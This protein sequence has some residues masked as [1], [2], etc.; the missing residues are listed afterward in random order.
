MKQREKINDIIQDTDRNYAP[1]YGVLP[2][3]IKKHDYK[4]GIEIGVFAGGHAEAILK[5]GAFLVGIDPYMDYEPGMPRLDNQSDW[6]ML[7]N[8]VMKRLYKYRYEHIKLTSNRAFP[9]LWKGKNDYDFLFI[10]GL[11][12]PEQ[13][14]KDLN[15]YTKL[16]FPGGVVAC[17]DYMHPSFPELTKIIDNYVKLNNKKL[18]I[19][20]L[21]LVWW[22]Q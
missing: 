7:H 2:E 11:H 17:H 14:Q 15:N 4:M 18:N 5:T 8:I 12:T 22:Y 6:N 13:L 10:D 3:L 19:G 21:H 9:L 20:P 1:Y 16:I